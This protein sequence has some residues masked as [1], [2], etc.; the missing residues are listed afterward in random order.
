MTA[1]A[2]EKASYVRD[3]LHDLARRMDL[4][5]SSVARIEQAIDA[6]AGIR[7]ITPES[8][9]QRPE[10]F[11]LPGLTAKPFWESAD[12]AWAGRLEAES[13]IIK[14]ELLRLRETSRFGQHPQSELVKEGVWA[15]YHFF[16]ADRKFE[17]NCARC[18]ETTKIIESIAEGKNCSLKYFSALA[19]GT[20]IQPHCGPINMR[21]RCHLGLS[22]PD[23]CG[24]R[25]GDQTRKWEEGK[26]LIFDDSFEHASWNHSDRTRFVLLI[27]FAHPELTKLEVGIIQKLWKIIDNLQD[28]AVRDLRMKNLQKPEVHN[29]PTNWWV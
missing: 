8:A 11:F 21:L 4:P 13:E 16:D 12:F 5:E 23:D 10:H 27:D 20:V 29:L 2:P 18:P 9:L 3:H 17:E 1:I 6:A 7:S 15:E 28:E 26:C 24:I 25:V 19:P 14:S 22:I